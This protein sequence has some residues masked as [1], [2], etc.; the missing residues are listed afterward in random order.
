MIK[1]AMLIDRMQQS[2]SSPFVLMSLH[3]REVSSAPLHR[4]STYSSTSYNLVLTKS[5]SS[6][7]K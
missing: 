6:N 1:S 3:A 4:N 2:K 7:K 5:S